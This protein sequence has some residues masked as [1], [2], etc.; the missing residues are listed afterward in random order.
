MKDEEREKSFGVLL[1]VGEKMTTTL[2]EQIKRSG[3]VEEE[4]SADGNYEPES[5]QGVGEGGDSHSGSGWEP[6]TEQENATGSDTSAAWDSETSKV[7]TAESGWDSHDAPLPDENVSS[8]DSGYISE[9]EESPLESSPEAIKYHQLPFKAKHYLLTY[10]Q[11]IL[12]ASCLKY[13]R[14][15]MRQ[16]LGD[17]V[18][19]NFHLVGFERHAGVD[20]LADDQIELEIWLRYFGCTTTVPQNSAVYNGA[21]AVRNVAIHRADNIHLTFGQA[22][23][24]MDLPLLL[25]DAEGG[26]DV[27]NAWKFV[28]G[29]QTLD[30]DTK[31]S[32]QKAL[33]TPQPCTT[34]HQVLARIQTLLEETCFDNAARRIPHVL[35]ERGWE[36]AEQ[37]ELQQWQEIF[38]RAGIECDDAANALF[39]TTYSLANLLWGARTRI[40]NHVAHSTPLPKWMMVEK[41][42]YAIDICLMQSDWERA[43][44]IEILAEMFLTKTSRET[45]LLRLEHAYRKGSIGS[46]YERERRVQIAGFLRRKQGCV[47]TPEEEHALVVADPCETEVP[48]SEVGESQRERT[49]SPS[50]HELL[51]TFDYSE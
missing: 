49:I 13:A 23:H 1:K 22:N 36:M 48:T 17:Q 38:I 45:V 35:A 34:T 3:S 41:V 43:I 26:R 39:P 32:V 47:L 42:H 9:E 14:T 31:A 50:M 21:L 4:S 15:H 7:G 33:Y 12:K 11:K 25:G 30:D 46:P 40:R 19:K 27:V 28:M 16:R 44:E 24:A 29:D 18:R 37:V 10:M 2:K 51:K 20:W 5:E 8:Y 6:E